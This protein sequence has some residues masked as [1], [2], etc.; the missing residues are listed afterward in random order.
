MKLSSSR[1]EMFNHHISCCTDYV[2][3]GPGKQSMNGAGSG[4]Q[5]QNLLDK[6]ELEGRLSWK[7]SGVP[8]NTS[9]EAL[10]SES[11]DGERGVMGGGFSIFF[12]TSIPLYLPSPPSIPP[13]SPSLLLPPPPPPPSPVSSPLFSHPQYSG[14]L[15]SVL[16]HDVKDL[17]TR[18]YQIEEEMAIDKVTSI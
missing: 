7:E 2:D 16:E 17:G 3:G 15:V 12:V 8:L 11:E 4:A 5:I 10:E 13:P 9:L 14:L 6:M 1:V 18:T